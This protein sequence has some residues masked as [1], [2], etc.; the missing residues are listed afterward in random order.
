MRGNEDVRPNIGG[1]LAGRLWELLPLGGSGRGPPTL[2]PDADDAMEGGKGGGLE[3]KV[4]AAMGL[5]DSLASISEL[6]KRTR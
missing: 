3:G 2:L 6:R 1:G 4:T 5:S